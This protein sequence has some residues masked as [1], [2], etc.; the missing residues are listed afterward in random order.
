VRRNTIYDVV[1]VFDDHDPQEIAPL[2]ERVDA[3]PLA[4][5]KMFPEVSK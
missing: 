2:V 5:L 3:D 1:D 4:F